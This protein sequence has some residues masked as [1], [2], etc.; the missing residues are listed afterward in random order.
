MKNYIE[1]ISYKKVLAPTETSAESPVDLVDETIQLHK[2]KII[3]QMK[4]ADLD[5]LFVYGDREHG[6]NFGYLTGF[7]P[8]FEE[9]LL[10]LHSNGSAYLLL[11]N[12]SL[13]MKQY[14]R[15]EAEAIQVPYFSLPNQPMQTD[16]TLAELIASAGVKEGMRVGIA[17]WKMF[18][19]SYEDNQQLFDTPY[20]IV[21]AVKELVKDT[22]NVLNATS[23]FI[24]PGTGA[25]TLMNANE[26]AHYEF[27]ASLAS[28][29]ILRVLD[30]LEPGKTEMELADGL[31]AY[32]Q[33][34]NVQTICATGDRFTNAVVAPRA[35]KVELGDK[36]SV[37]VGYRGGLTNRSAYVVS[38]AEELP[39]DV[40]DYIDVV[41]K[42][43]YA[44]GV[45]WYE[46]VRI[47]MTGGEM[48]ELIESVL[49]KS[50]F[51]WKLNPGHL[52][53]GEEWMS[54]PIYPNSE[55]QL[56]SGMML[57]VD[58][59]PSVPG[60]GG[61]NAEDGIALADEELR[62]EL[63]AHYPEL[64]E[65]IQTRREYMI[66]TLGI[67]LHPEVLPMSTINGYY[68]PYLLN[69]EYAFTVDQQ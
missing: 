32:G 11:G 58:I 15:I 34:N 59:I 46:N 56:A 17:G 33:P 31:A 2:E 25:R 42:P 60:Y 50:K 55:I 21:N 57:Q 44:A 14:S 16:K 22:G 28:S 9:A 29:R 30:K 5:V 63:S 18:T 48:Y 7:E 3:A 20:F 68:R 19:S 26:I 54:S 41:A 23:L 53:A 4:N 8:R 51:G 39:T 10:A 38:S 69:K 65:R 40:S 6:T 12:E 1:R 35:K 62:A 37:T 61:A 36:F 13:R 24:H 64:W 67:Q 27:G 49:P 66:N 52:T 43:Y 47:G 45:A